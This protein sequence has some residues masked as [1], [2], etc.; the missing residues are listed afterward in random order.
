MAEETFPIFCFAKDG[1]LA[2]S[3]GYR[4]VASEA[5]KQG[6]P[7]AAHGLFHEEIVRGSLIGHAREEHMLPV[8]V[9]YDNFLQLLTA[10][11]THWTPTLVA[12]FSLIPEG[13]P[14]RTAMLA[15]V[16]RAHLAVISHSVA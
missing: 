7:V 4:A 11:R 8:N 3:R 14:L 2:V 1:K 9:Y 12:E 6:L 13:A 16:R 15:E 10:T 5:F